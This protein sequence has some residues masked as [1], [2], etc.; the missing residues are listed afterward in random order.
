MP[1]YEYK[2]DSCEYRFEKLQK[3]SDSPISICPS[4]NKKTAN[5]LVSASKFRLSGNGWYE[6]DFKTSNDTKRNLVD[7]N[8]S[9]STASNTSS[10]TN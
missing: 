2:C 10:D 7:S 8:N 1:I 5:K 4:C 3:I 6:T 9:N